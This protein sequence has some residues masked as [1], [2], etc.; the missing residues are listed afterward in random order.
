M[1]TPPQDLKCPFKTLLCAAYLALPSNSPTKP[2]VSCLLHAPVST[3][4][5]ESN[6]TPFFGSG[7]LLFPRTKD[8]LNRTRP[9]LEIEKP[10]A[11]SAPDSMTTFADKPFVVQSPDVTYT[12]DEMV[13]K[14]TYQ[15]LHTRLSTVA[16]GCSLAFCAGD[17]LLVQL[18][19][20]E[21][22]FRPVFSHRHQQR[23]LSL[24]QCFAR[25]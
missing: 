7:I 11:S 21:P 12:D 3:I 9:C 5:P 8:L 13:S 24:S 4:L 6:A 20:H 22:Q 16:S 15:V 17:S 2:Q 23:A 19:F 1:M 25:R 10:S 14:Y 18:V